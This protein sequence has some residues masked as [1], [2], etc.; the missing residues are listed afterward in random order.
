MPLT[1]QPQM[2]PP[3][4]KLEGRRFRWVQVFGRLA[5]GTTIDTLRARLD[6]LYATLLADEATDPAFN[7]ASAETRR[8][9]LAGRLTVLPAPQGPGLLRESLDLPLRLLMAVAFGVLL[10][11]CANVANLLIARGVSRQRELALRVA[12]GAGRARLA[13]LMLAEALLL[14]VAGSAVGLVLA[15][16]GVCVPG[17]D[18]R[19]DRRGVPGTGHRGWT[20]PRV[21]HRHHRADGARV[22]P[23]PR[24]SQPAA[25]AGT[26]AEGRGG[27]RRAG[28]AAAPPDAGRRAGRPVV[29]AAGGVGPVRAQPRQPA[30]DALGAGRRSRAVVPGLAGRRRVLGGS[31]QSVRRRAAAPRAVPAG[32]ARGGRG[33]DRHPRGRRV[34]ARLSPWKASCRNPARPPTRWPTP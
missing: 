3:W 1:M 28:T 33:H 27:R 14:A 12:L 9:F 22:G 13:W 26:G 21:H 25:V 18:V 32:R 29:P 5:D 8:A 11:A 4:L 7:A 34:V 19:P 16:W 31:Q 6:P 24:A 15:G 23:R 2:G 17:R 20:H 30:A 10:I